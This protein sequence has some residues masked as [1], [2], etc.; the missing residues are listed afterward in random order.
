MKILY[1]VRG[2]PGSGKSTLA[3]TIADAAVEADSYFYVKRDKKTGEIVKRHY[4]DGE[5]VFDTDLL[6]EA[7]KECKNLCELHMVFEV[8]KLAVAN[9][10]TQ[11]WEM[12]PY[13]D[14]AKKY[15]Y[16]VFSIIVENRHGSTNIHGA[17]D[18]VISAMASR[19][20]IVL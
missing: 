8:D 4:H 3:R 13:F 9:T 5:Y 2:C 18:N 12:K 20:E 6:G 11:E 17:P 14:L 10:F 15:G 19:F 16:T 1:L 7:H